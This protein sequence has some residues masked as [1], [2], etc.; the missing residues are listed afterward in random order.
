MSKTL[1]LDKLDFK[2]SKLTMPKGTKL[3]EATLK[4]GKFSREQV[5]K[6]VNALA[7]QFCDPLVKIGVSI[8][9]KKMNAWGTGLMNHSNK[10][11]LVW[12]PDDSPDTKEAYMHDS[13]DAVHFMVLKSNIK[14]TKTTHR[15]PKKAVLDK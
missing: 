11:I 9:Y 10:N 5:V 7:R 14:D 2:K 12:N 15:T 3:L 6:N 4:K 8:H 1:F 13:I